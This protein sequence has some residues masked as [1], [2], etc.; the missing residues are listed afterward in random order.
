MIAMIYTMMG[1]RITAWWTGNVLVTQVEDGPILPAIP[2]ASEP[3]F[4]L[5]EDP[6]G[7]LWLVCLDS[8]GEIT[9]YRSTDLGVTWEAV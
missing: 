2:C 3:G 9:R 7:A 6:T 5:A 4:D 1:L 8:A